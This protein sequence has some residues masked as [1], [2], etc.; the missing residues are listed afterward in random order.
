MTGFSHKAIINYSDLTAAAGSQALTIFPDVSNNAGA[1]LYAGWAITKVAYRL[2]AGF[3]SGLP[4]AATLTL[5]DGANATRYLAAAATDLYTAPSGTNSKDFVL[6]STSYAYS[7]NDAT[8][9][10]AKLVATIAVAAG[11]VSAVTAGQVEIYFRADDL[12]PLAQ[13]VEPTHVASITE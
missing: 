6:G 1:L 3:T 8:N 13:V 11:N 5:G 4:I 10:N 12:T 2:I 9:S 7:S